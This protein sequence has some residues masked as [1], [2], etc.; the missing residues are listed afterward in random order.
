MSATQPLAVAL[1]R[2]RDTLLSR[3]EGRLSDL[4]ATEMSRWT[5]VRRNLAA[6]LC[7]VTYTPR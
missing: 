1:A 7:P 3:V 5:P 6:R 4:L 2:A